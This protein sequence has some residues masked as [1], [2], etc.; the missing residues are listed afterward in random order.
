MQLYYIASWVL[1]QPS[2]LSGCILAAYVSATA[3]SSESVPSGNI[4]KLHNVRMSL[5]HY[6]A[7]IS[8]YMLHNKSAHIL[9][10]I[11]RHIITIKHYNHLLPIKQH[12]I[13]IFEIYSCELFPFVSIY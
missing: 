11:L 7:L 1:L 12:I 2:A 8:I 3:T 5:V 13:S 4:V 10:D 6:P 9:L